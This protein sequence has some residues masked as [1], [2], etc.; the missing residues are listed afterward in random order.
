MYYIYNMKNT[1]ITLTDDREV[2]LYT[3]KNWEGKTKTLKC[4]PYSE[5]PNLIKRTGKLGM[6]TYYAWKLDWTKYFD[7]KEESITFYN[8]II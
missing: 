8:S 4:F 6:T 1:N 3:Y 5:L 7:T 2:V